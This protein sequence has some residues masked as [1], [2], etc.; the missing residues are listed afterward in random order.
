MKLPESTLACVYQGSEHADATSISRQSFGDLLR[1]EQRRLPELGLGK[2]LLRVESAPVNPSDEL[3]IRGMYGVKPKAGDVPGFEGCGTVVAANCGPYGWWLKGQRVSFGNQDGN[4]SWAQY[5]VVSAF[6]CIPISRQ[7][8][9]EVAATLIVNPMT[10]IGL[11]ERARRHG[12][13][14]VVFNAAG[15]ALGRLLIPLAKQQ[16]IEFIGLVRREETKE[17]V[18]SL[19]AD[20]V[21]NTNAPGFLKQ[22]HEVCRQRQARVLLD[23]VA[24]QQTA[25]LM[26]QMPDESLAVVYGKLEEESLGSDVAVSSVSTDAD[27]LVFRKQRVEGYWLSHELHGFNGVF[28][29]LIR[30]RRI[31]QMFRRGVLTAG[32]FVET[33]LENLVRQLDSPER[34]GKLLYRADLPT[35]RHPL[36]HHLHNRVSGESRVANS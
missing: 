8:P 23:A 17:Q 28:T 29:P 32:Q 1:I 5:V 11:L 24:G 16:G 25:A 35:N 12:T 30:A 6:S 19:G 14:A 22:L 15:S 3:Y 26:N 7:L 2:V 18:L 27:A 20:V 31:S 13:R 9:I 33:P 10:A 34:P 4:G 36:K 21:F